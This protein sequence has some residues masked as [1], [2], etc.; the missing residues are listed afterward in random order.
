MVELGVSAGTRWPMEK[1]QEFGEESRS[2]VAVGS[3]SSRDTWGRR[4]CSGASER[5]L[6]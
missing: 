6:L 5:V 3:A 4:G 1:E 2:G